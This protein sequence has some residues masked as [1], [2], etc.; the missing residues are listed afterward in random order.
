M[1]KLSDLGVI[2][3]MMMISLLIAGINL[4]KYLYG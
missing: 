3:L 4:L 1:K 2:E